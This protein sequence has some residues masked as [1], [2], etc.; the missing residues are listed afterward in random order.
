[1]ARYLL[2]LIGIVRSAR[3][4]ISA[5]ALILAVMTT[6]TVPA[7]AGQVHL[8]CVTQ[9]HD[10][11]RTAAIKPCCCGGQGESPNQSGPV[12]S[13][14]RLTA[15]VTPACADLVHIAPAVLGRIARINAET[16]RAASFG[17]SS[18][19]RSLLI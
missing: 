13:T 5:L 17:L 12:E 8:V 19:F 9:V 11:G 3:S 1:V 6:A 4:F 7:V 2:S 18:L 14:V 10:C 15:P 16:V